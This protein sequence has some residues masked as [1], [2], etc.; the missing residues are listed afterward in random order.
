MSQPRSFL[1]DYTGIIAA[2]VCLIHCLAAPVL[3][4]A[5]AGMQGHEHHADTPWYLHHF[6]DYI[7]LAIGFLA[8]RYSANHTPL[9]WMKVLLWFSFLALGMSIFLEHYSEVFRNLVY[10][11]SS[12]LIGSHLYNMRNLWRRSSPDNAE[13]FD[14]LTQPVNQAEVL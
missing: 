2:F 3:L 12:L 5:T 4:G 11:A 8:V 1:A 6:W 9:K 10:V 7:F 13:G 14:P